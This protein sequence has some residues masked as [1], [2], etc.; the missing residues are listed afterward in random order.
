MNDE[1]NCQNAEISEQLVLINIDQ[2]WHSGC[3]GVSAY[4]AKHHVQW[5]DWEERV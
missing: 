2:E 5:I 4:L 1:V 3:E